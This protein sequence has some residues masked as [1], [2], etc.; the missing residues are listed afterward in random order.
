MKRLFLI[1][2]IGY[3]LAGC[4]LSKHEGKQYQWEIEQATSMQKFLLDNSLDKGSREAST[5]NL[6]K[7]M[8]YIKYISCLDSNRRQQVRFEKAK[9]KCISESQITLKKP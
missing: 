5:S 2:F 4:A 1:I 8:R 9:I 7:S 6:N 3:L